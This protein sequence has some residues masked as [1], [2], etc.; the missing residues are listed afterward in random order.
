MYWKVL[1]DGAGYTA[2]D[3][4]DL[5]DAEQAAQI[6]RLVPLAQ[7]PAPADAPAGKPAAVVELTSSAP[8]P[9]APKAHRGKRP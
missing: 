9:S 4:L 3:V 8:P 6:A 7:V 2:G 5:A 1:I